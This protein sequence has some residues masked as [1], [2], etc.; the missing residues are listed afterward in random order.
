MKKTKEENILEELE[1]LRKENKRLENNLRVMADIMRGV[2]DN[3]RVIQTSINNI[4]RIMSPILKQ[5]D[6][7]GED[8][9][10]DRPD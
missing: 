9:D 4:Y 1:R 10:T 7:S 2:L 3:I 8:R 6:N 5:G